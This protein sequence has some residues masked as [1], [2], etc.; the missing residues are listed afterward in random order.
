MLEEM[1]FGLISQF[2]KSSDSE[3]DLARLREDNRQLYQNH[4][5]LNRKY[6]ELYQRWR[7]L[8]QE[9][10]AL[11]Q[12][13][14]KL[15]QANAA[16]EQGR[17]ALRATVKQLNLQ[18]AQLYS[19]RMSLSGENERLRLANKE[20]LNRLEA[21][22]QAQD[23]QETA[24]R[25]GKTGQADTSDVLAADVQNEYMRCRIEEVM[26]GL[27]VRTYNALA[28]NYINTLG[29]V[30]E[31]SALEL[32]KM[33]CFGV[34]SLN[35]LNYNLGLLGLKLANEGT[36]KKQAEVD[37]I[38]L[39]SRARLTTLEKLD[40]SEQTYDEAKKAGFSTAES[41]IYRSEEEIRRQFSCQKHADELLKK[42]QALGFSPG[43][44]KRRMV[45]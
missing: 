20:L 14:E 17:D 24:E 28:R 13:C 30:C 5:A 34:S 7:E 29:G 27:S 2:C 43:S 9:N 39:P 25:E 32:L 1:L 26:T 18:N 23:G 11:K 37:K 35:N 36:T 21:A 12:K 40:L 10:K 44:V 16:L 38:L 6:E 3:V 15:E 45:F 8:D 19:E 33:R 22:S 31:Y 42:A 41:V 4:D